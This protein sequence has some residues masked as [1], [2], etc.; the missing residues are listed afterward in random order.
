MARLVHYFCFQH[1]YLGG[2]G[3]L[4]HEAR[5]KRLMDCP[6]EFP[7]LQRLGLAMVRL[8]AVMLVF[9]LDSLVSV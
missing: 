5:H 6:D 1:S 9:L 4:E 8:C 2:N 7:D 3:A